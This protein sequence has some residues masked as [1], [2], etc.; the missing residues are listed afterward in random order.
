MTTNPNIS[1]RGLRRAAVMLIVLTTASGA[2]AVA[3]GL[4]HHSVSA[5]VGLTACGV[6][7][8]GL[9]RVSRWLDADADRA[10]LAG[11]ASGAATPDELAADLGLRVAVVRLS[12][13]RLRNSGQV[14]KDGRGFVRRHDR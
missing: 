6:S 2:I 4:L 12:L 8:L 7:A 3:A 13:A 5:A 11:L 1:R 10:V 14:E 9:H